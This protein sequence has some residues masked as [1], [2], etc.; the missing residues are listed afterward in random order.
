MHIKTLTPELIRKVFEKTGVAPF[1]P[2]VISPEMMALSRETLLEGPLLLIPP[3]PVC[4]AAVSLHHL[5]HPLSDVGQCSG[6]SV[7]PTSNNTT[8]SLATPSLAISHTAHQL[9]LLH[10]S[11]QSQPL[12]SLQSRHTLLISSQQI[13]RQTRRNC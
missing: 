7:G 5:F 4:T 11:Q 12:L 6:L 13:Q 3:T 10:N 8:D 1:N 2:N 9:K